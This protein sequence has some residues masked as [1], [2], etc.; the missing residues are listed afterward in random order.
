[1]KTG[2]YPGSF[3]PITNGHIDIIQRGLRVVDRLII[4]IGVSESKTPLLSF[5][6]RQAMISEEISP[7]AKQQG[8]ELAVVEFKGLL[9]Q[10]AREL[11]A[12][13]ILRGLRTA[14]DFEYEAQ[15]TAMNRVMAPEIETI[16]LTASPEM[17]VISSTL[18]RQIHAMGGDISPFVPK[19]VIKLMK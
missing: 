16:F 13:L 8:V 10:Q 11:G 1:M 2:L 19:S 3:D 12:S 17:S 18:V 4:G 6:Q 5:A 14:G 9:V 15:M 7:L